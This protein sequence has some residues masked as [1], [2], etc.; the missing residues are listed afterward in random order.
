MPRSRI[1]IFVF[2]LVL[3]T[4]LTMP[5]AAQSGIQVVNNAANLTFP[6]SIVFNAG[7]QGGSDITSVVLE[8]GVNQ[9]TCG[10]VD[11]K[12]FPQLTPGTDVKVTWTWQMLESGSLAPGTTVWWHWQVTDST[13]AQFNSPTK[14]VMW[15]DSVHF[16]Q[17]ITGGSINL[18]YY[19]GDASFGQQLHDAAAQAL[20]RLSQDVGVTTDSPVDIYIY[21][22]QNDL[23]EAVHYDPSWA[24][25]QAFP[26][27]NIVIIDVPPDQLDEGKSTEAHELT[28]VLVGHLTFSCL[29]VIPQWLNEGLAVYGQ[30]G[31]SD[32]Q[33][34]L[35]QA[36]ADN[37]LTSLRSLSGNFPDTS[38][39]TL[40]YG[41]SYSVVDFMIKTYG[42]DKMTSLLLDLKNGQT[43][44]QALQAVYDFDTN[45]LETAWRSSIGAK[46][47]ASA[48]SQPTPSPTPTIIP[49]YVPI[50]AAPLAV[51]ELITP[52]PTQANGAQ[53]PTTVTQGPI[54]TPGAP[55]GA[56]AK[57]ANP[58]GLAMGGITPVLELGLACLVILVL[59][60]GLIIYL[61]VRSQ[62]RSR[63]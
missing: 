27:N 6:D 22:S 34:A 9:L 57:T 35:A 26:E 61:V 54:P 44:D 62:N 43:I 7:F 15:L 47:L 48:S 63:K 38:L 28:H 59:L 39:V 13:G 33:A 52:H 11:A 16:W 46:P 29:G 42:R 18:H 56:P 12:A 5:A 36:V 10:T 17:V 45:G 60:A 2:M 53:A 55:S 25:G 37:T 24:D 3:L 32:F 21:A 14:T 8:Y 50:S 23:L 41:E 31:R 51:S 58:L 20:V 19:N 30:G 1:I 49:T 4:C 40:A